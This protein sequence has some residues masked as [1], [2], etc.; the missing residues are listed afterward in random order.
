MRFACNNP[1]K[2]TFFFVEIML[3]AFAGYGQEVP[4]LIEQPSDIVVA[5][6]QP[7]TL[8]CSAEGEPP[9]VITWFKDG[10][11]LIPTVRRVILPAGGLF[12]LRTS[13]ARRDS[14]SG[15]YWC[16]ATNQYGTARSR[17][18]NFQVGSEYG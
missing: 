18:A 15:V 5:R 8:Q 13:H 11:A 1:R 7:A 14:D 17:K 9:P 12:F 10:V 3:I 16:E 2:K 6:Y 4:R